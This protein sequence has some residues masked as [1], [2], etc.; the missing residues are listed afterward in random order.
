MSSKPVYVVMEPG[1]VRDAC[2][3]ALGDAAQVLD[4]PLDAAAL[5]AGA[6]G[7]VL[8]QLEGLSARA[9][10]DAASRLTGPGW[11]LAVLDPSDP[12]TARTVSL[13]YGTELDRVAAFAAHE[14]E[15]AE[16]LLEL[17]RV[18]VEVARARHDVNN[19]LTSA[20]AETQILLLDAEQG[21]VREGLEIVQ[22][23]LRRIRDLVAA[24]RHIRP[25]R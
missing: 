1:A 2:V 8:L 9:L 10:V 4:P 14:G 18:L 12:P 16:D 6:P 17:H 7:V 25:R 22:T 15:G 13:G 24:T 20:L 19:P 21:E 5:A 11:T 23:Q 3:S